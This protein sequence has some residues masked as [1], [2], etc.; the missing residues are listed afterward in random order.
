MARPKGSKNKNNTKQQVLTVKKIKDDP[1]LP[2]KSLFRIDE[3]ADYFSVNASSIR[4]WI[5][6]GILEK[7]KIVGVVRIPRES[8]LQC[9]FRKVVVRPR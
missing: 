2:N 8:I 3:V 6:H 4:R 7:E 9:R 5:D 1:R